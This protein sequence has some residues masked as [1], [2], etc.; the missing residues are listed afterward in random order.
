MD[1]QPI[2]PIT[3]Q[4]PYNGTSQWYTNYQLLLQG[5]NYNPGLAKKTLP[6]Q[7]A[8][9]SAMG[10]RMESDGVRLCHA[11]SN[12]CLGPGLE[13]DILAVA[14]HPMTNDILNGV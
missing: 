8:M 11:G 3:N 1:K 6:V 13:I 12:T 7:A 5:T 2:V 4:W 9:R 14:A 10:T